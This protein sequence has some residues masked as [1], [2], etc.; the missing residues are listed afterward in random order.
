MSSK[1]SSIQPRS[2]LTEPIASKTPLPTDHQH[3]YGQYS[4]NILNN[5]TW[6]S[7]AKS[8]QIDSEM[9]MTNTDK[10]LRVW[11]HKYNA[12]EMAW[13]QI[14]ALWSKGQWQFNVGKTELIN[15]FGKRSMWNSHVQPAMRNINEYQVMIEWLERAEDDTEPSD[16]E[17]WGFTKQVYT[18]SNLEAWKRKKSGG[19]KQKRTA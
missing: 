16:L 12:Y 7:V 14:Q 11:Y 8:L 6:L 18:F 15:L 10:D 4:T 1:S 3:F 17:V 19:L 2:L 13:T 5:L 9:M